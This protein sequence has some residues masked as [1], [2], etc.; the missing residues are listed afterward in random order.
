M[1][2]KKALVSRRFLGKIDNFVDKQ[3]KA[4]EKKHLK[5]YLKG[6]KKF[7]VGHKPNAITGIIEPEYH[8]VKQE[9]IKNTIL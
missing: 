2:N 8:D 5:A 1:K 6:D 4:Y 3:E 9:I 7:L